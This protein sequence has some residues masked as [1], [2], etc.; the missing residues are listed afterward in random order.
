MI[1][2]PDQTRR[3]VA[4]RQRPVVRDRRRRPTHV[5]RLLRFRIAQQSVT[6]LHRPVSIWRK[7]ESGRTRIPLVGVEVVTVFIGL[8]AVEDRAFQFEPAISKPG[9]QNSETNV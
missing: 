9:S 7:C 2:S 6:H 5:A 3:P 4:P 8:A 1:A